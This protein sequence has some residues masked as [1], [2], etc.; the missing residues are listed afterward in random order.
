MQRAM[1]VGLAWLATFPSHAANVGEGR[2]QGEARIPGWPLALVIDLAPQP[3]NEWVGS[4]IVTGV[5]IK[6]A[7]LSHLVVGATGVSFDLGPVLAGPA[8]GPTKFQLRAMTDGS[9]EGDMRQAG[10]VASVSL[11]RT[12]SA[13][14]DA[15]ARSTAVRRELEQQWIGEFELGGYPRH[16]TLTFTNHADAAAT[17]QF[18]VVGKQ[19]TD[20]PIDLVQQEDDWLRFESRA[21]QA[22]FEGRFVPS[23]NEI[24]GTLALGSVELPLVLRGSTK[25]EP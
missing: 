6:G 1:V 20:L 3:D 8:D 18:I 14:V 24:S 16:V 11:H 21:F 15:P 22:S 12:G 7:P 23:A 9:L 2:W 10:N 13:Q 25:G 17:A 19:R 5:G 4:I